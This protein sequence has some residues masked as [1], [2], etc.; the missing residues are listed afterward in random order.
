M[1]NI[2]YPCVLLAMLL[3]AQAVPMEQER[4]LIFNLVR[5]LTP[6]LGTP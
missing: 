5:T 4:G 3:L 1:A 6:T 2:L